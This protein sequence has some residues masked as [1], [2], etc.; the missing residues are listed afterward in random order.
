M[1]KQVILEHPITGKQFHAECTR[2]AS[3][4]NVIWDDS[5]H[6]PIDP[7]W[8]ESLGGLSR[9]ENSPGVFDIE[10]D[11]VAAQAQSDD[12]QTKRNRDNQIRNQAIQAA[13]DMIANPVSSLTTNAD[14]RQEVARQRRILRY[15]FTQ[16]R[17]LQN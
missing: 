1:K 16:L 17:D 15:L 6:G 14:L 11:P 7:S 4:V 9:V 10:I 5:I 12:D 3:E 8:L 2:V 13:Q